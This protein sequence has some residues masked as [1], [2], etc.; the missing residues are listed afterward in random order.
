ME[1]QMRNQVTNIAINIIAM[2][3]AGHPELIEG[4][5]IYVANPEFFGVFARRLWKA[6]ITIIGGCCGTR[7]N[8]IRRM[9]NA[10][11]MMLASGSMSFT[12]SASGHAPVTPRHRVCQWARASQPA[13][14]ARR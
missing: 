12:S 13:K 1:K 14:S 10:A 4:R 9:A 3:N 8:H 5:T 11:R 6:G 2:A 7:P